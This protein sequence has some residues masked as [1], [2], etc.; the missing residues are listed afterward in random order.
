MG[1][2]TTNELL[3]GPIDRAAFALEW[4]DWHRVHETQRADPHGF[5]A[6]T[7]IHWLD[8]APQSIDGVPGAWSTGEDG[9]VVELADGEVLEHDGTILS[10]RHAFGRIAERDGL[11][12]RAGEIAVEVARRGGQDIVRP[13]DPRHPYLA[14]YAGT[15]T[16]LPNPRWIA[17]GRFVPH[18]SPREVTVGS[19]AEGLQHV[20]ETPGEVEFELRGE[21][22][23]LTAFNG[24]APGS[25]LILFTDATSGITTYA[26]NRSL[27]V[28]APTEDGSVVLD[29]NRAVNLP[30]AYTDHATCPLPPAENRLPVG[31][32]AGEK[33][34][35]ERQAA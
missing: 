12:L 8:T 1:D 25:L 3:T 22:F 10:G 2:M 24:H 15:P 34:P 14:R 21:V 29:F 26:A 11:V 18:E 20:Y 32:E 35:V 17:R 30:C 9:P 13:R 27:G 28:D 5:L 16:Y 33:T 7:G 23:R 6:V 31:I 4:E 19:A